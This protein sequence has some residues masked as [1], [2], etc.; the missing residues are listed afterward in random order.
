[1][2]NKIL[3]ILFIVPAFFSLMVKADE[4]LLKNGD[5]ITGTILNK[6]GNTLEVKTKYPLTGI[7]LKVSVQLSLCY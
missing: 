4:I 7:Q 2:K 1:M 3:I 6:T 5:R